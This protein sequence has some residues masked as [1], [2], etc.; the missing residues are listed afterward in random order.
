M[1]TTLKLCPCGYSYIL[2]GMREH[3]LLS[4]ICPQCNRSV[5]A[6]T[7]EGLR[8]SV[9]AQLYCWEWNAIKAAIMDGRLRLV[10]ESPGVPE[11]GGV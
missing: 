10:N 3:G 9:D 5:Q 1:S 6:L 8:I 4:L 2:A 11:G 7:I